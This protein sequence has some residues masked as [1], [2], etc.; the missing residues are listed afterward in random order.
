MNNRVLSYNLTNML[1]LIWISFVIFSPLLSSFFI[2][3]AYPIA[4]NPCITYEPS[5]RV[6]KI[7]CQSANLTN[8]YKQLHNKDILNIQPSTNDSNNGKKS[9]WLLNASLFIAKGSTFFINS[10]D[11]SW[12]KIISP[13]RVIDNS[14]IT[15]SNVTTTP[16]RID[17][18]GSL[19]IN[20]V[21]ITSWNPEN[22]N[23]ALTNGTVTNPGIARPFIKI[24]HSATGTADI[25]NSEIAYL[26]SEG[27][28]SDGLY[29]A[30]G[31]GSVIR[32][33]NIH[34]N[35]FAIYFNGVSDI[36]LENNF[37]HDSYFYGIDPHTAVHNMTIRNNTVYNNGAQGIICSLDCYDIAIEGNS[38]HNNVGSGIMFSRNMSNSVAR[39]NN[40]FNETIGI[41][42]S[43]SHNNQV[44]NNLIS[45]SKTG[46][47]LRNT[48]SDNIVNNNTIF[49]PKLYGLYVS[50]N[51][52]NNIFSSNT[53]H[54][55]SFFGIYVRNSSTI[56]NLFKD[57][58]L[59]NPISYG[60]GL[61]NNKATRFINNTI[62]GES[63]PGNDRES[64][65]F[66]NSKKYDY[67]IEKDSLLNLQKTIFSN[68]HIAPE[69]LTNNS[70]TIFNSGAI[71]ITDS[72]ID[73]A[74]TFNTNFSP[75]I[76]TFTTSANITADTL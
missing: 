35:W 21:K 43:Q 69:D 65:H 61:S 47:Y 56:N 26:G 48:S 16:Y 51:A 41:L 22:S 34:N 14:S 71:N 17:V 59:V 44:Y 5:T 67:I 75:F 36:L 27:D 9:I 19:K 74:T 32:N 66:Q 3:M 72:R 37:V 52:S 62:I 57:N 1:V 76:H 54:N 42:V 10:T 2:Q 25:S 64:T 28:K 38:V 29:Y 18:Y 31:D 8:V 23:Y 60:I 45:D 33:N 40:I 24:E 12:V 68:D 6:I 4:P 39:D 53:V 7:T 58:D 30:G 13:N 11:T 50:T 20:L 55:P 15:N 73:K 46:I 49:N 63:G 70:V